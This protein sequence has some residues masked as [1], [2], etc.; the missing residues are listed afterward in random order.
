MIYEQ[1]FSIVIRVVF[2]DSPSPPQVI[3]VLVQNEKVGRSHHGCV[4]V[5][6][7]SWALCLALFTADSVNQNWGCAFLSYCVEQ[8]FSS[9][10][11]FPARAFLCLI[12]S[13]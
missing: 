2:C 12:D 6:T 5:A 11:V 4:A 10:F 8:A 9:P 1:H 13:L 7:T 3:R